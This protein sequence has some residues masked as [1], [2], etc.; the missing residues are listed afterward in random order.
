MKKLSTAK[1]SIETDLLQFS[2]NQQSVTRLQEWITDR[3][4]RLQQVKEQRTV[5]I[6]RIDANFV[7]NIVKNEM[8]KYSLYL[9]IPKKR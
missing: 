7:A 9:I 3:E 6:T 1:V 4:T 2:D 8:R 5:M